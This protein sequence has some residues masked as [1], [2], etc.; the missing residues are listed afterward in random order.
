MS[1]E[2][3][4]ADAPV[5][6]LD[7]AVCS[8]GA[9]S[10]RNL[11]VTVFGDLVLPSETTVGELSVQTLAGL[12]GP[13]A[14]G[15]R[16]VRTSLSRIVGEGLLTARTE[17]RRSHYSVAESARPTF[18]RADRRIYRG[19]AAN[20]HD[21]WDGE[22]TIVII[23]GTSSTTSDRADLRRRLGW[24]GFGSIGP[25]VMA[26]PLVDA[27]AAAD[28][29]GDVVPATVMISRSRVLDRAR[30]IGPEQLVRRSVDLEAAEAAHGDLLARFGGFDGSVL[31]D[32][33]D[34]RSLKLRVLLVSTFRRVAL[35][36]PDVPA[37]LLPADWVGHRSRRLAARIYE[38]IVERSDRAAGRILG[39]MPSTPPDRFGP[40]TT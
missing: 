40:P 9:P 4:P 1:L 13:F 2:T 25:N 27:D 20:P 11:I 32:L 6:A 10:A 39:A 18:E 8:D 31:D 7:R 30:L 17:G 5:D 33:D 15:E 26:S 24:A 35:A 38:A 12:L 37:S 28:I 14:V 16:L 21:E 23:D 36:E 19:A 3:S 22:W 29:V 34:D